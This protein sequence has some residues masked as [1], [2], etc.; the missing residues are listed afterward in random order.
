M[1]TLIYLL[2]HDPAAVRKTIAALLG[3]V[4]VAIAVGLLPTGIGAWLA[5]AVSLASSMGVY[6]VHNTRPKHEQV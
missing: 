5:V 4:G 3:A 2:M 6:A 1:K